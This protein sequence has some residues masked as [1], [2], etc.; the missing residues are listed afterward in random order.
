MQILSTL[1]SLI[2][3]RLARTTIYT[4]IGLSMFAGISTDI[5]TIGGVNDTI[6]ISTSYAADAPQKDLTTTTNEM[7]TSLVSFGNILI[8]ILTFLLTPLIM[9]AGWL[10]SPDWTM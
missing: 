3:S 6:G 7:L 8:G 4:L 9:L 5:S 1:K 10:L 2:T